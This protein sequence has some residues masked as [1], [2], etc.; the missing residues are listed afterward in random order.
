M[1]PLL[2]AA[3][4]AA[5]CAE[6]KREAAEK[7]GPPPKQKPIELKAAP[8]S[9]AAVAR[10]LMDD[11]PSL[12]GKSVSLRLLVGYSGRGKR[13]PEQVG[14][15]VDFFGDVE[16][17]PVKVV[18]HIPRGMTVPNVGEGDSAVVTF[19]CGGKLDAGNVATKIAR[20]E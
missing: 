12:K 13:L 19:T 15:D 3:V 10:Q 17:V 11:T 8:E 2:L 18:V 9:K 1:R 7:V 16:Q 14:C 5:G 4:L 6:P 20:P